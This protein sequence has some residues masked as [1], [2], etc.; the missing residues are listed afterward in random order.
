MRLLPQERC[1]GRNLLP[2]R[3]GNRQ[4]SNYLS[5]PWISTPK[6]R[7]AASVHPRQELWQS[8]ADKRHPKLYTSVTYASRGVRALGSCTGQGSL[9]RDHSGASS[10]YD[11]HQKND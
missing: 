7:V 8:R 9:S 4:Q 6:L 1:V 5:L 11:A 2:D 10:A 3:H